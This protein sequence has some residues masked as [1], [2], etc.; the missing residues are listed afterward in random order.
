VNEVFLI[1][2]S[3][4]TLNRSARTLVS[5]TAADLDNS[6]RTPHEPEKTADAHADEDEENEA[7]QPAGPLAVLVVTVVAVILPRAIRVGRFAA[8]ALA[9]GRAQLALVAV[10]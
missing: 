8:L 10:A 9:T 5:R 3:E 1:L 6:R 7:K 4:Q 2:S